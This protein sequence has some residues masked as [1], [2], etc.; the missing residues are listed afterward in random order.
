MTL[1]LQ[2]PPDLEQRLAQEATRHGVPVDV[3]TL[4]VLEQCV[5]PKDRTTE[6]VNLLQSWIDEADSED[7]RETG[8]YLIHALDDDR[9]SNRR[10]FTPDLRGV[11]W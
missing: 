6:V 1:T 7:Q 11:T 9:S 3:Y 5:P 2:L 4:R 8:E 10:L